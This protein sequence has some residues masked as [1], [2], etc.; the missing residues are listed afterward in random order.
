MRAALFEIA[1]QL[2]LEISEAQASSLLGHL[3]L[4]Q[5]WNETYNLTA[6][7]SPAKMLTQHLADCL[8]VVL[9][10]R[11]VAGGRALR[12]LDVG[13]GGGLP[14]IVLAVMNPELDVTCVDSVGKKAA[15]IRQAAA[16]LGLANAHALHSRVPLLSAATSYDVITARAF[17]SLADL[18]QFTRQ[19]LSVDGF[20]M[21]LKGKVPDA[22][23]VE[24]APDVDVFHV[25]QVVVP[26][27]E[28][29]RCI[30]W[31]RT[32]PSL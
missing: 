17:A 3:A 30:V 13:S 9:P 14:G 28:A 18:V 12:V 7:N 29:D 10:L 4:L 6:V 25:E 22:E 15:F 16:E 11:R 1:S 26:G 5:R 23:I 24:L 20:W 27:L 2:G 19:H 32:R 21:A 31:M 8:A